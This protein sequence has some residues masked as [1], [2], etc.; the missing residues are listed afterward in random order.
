MHG[1]LADS[2]SFYNQLEY[3]GR[4]FDVFAPDFKGFGKNKGMEYAYSLDD[5]ILDLK[6]YAYKHGLKNPHVIAHSFGARV[7]VKCAANDKDFFDKIV[8]TGA[9]GLKPKLSLIKR[10]KKGA[11]SVLKKFVKK[12]RLKA[13]YSKDYL[14][15]DPVMKESFVKIVNEHLDGL[16]GDIVNETLIIYGSGDKDTP[17]YMAKRFHSGINGSKLIFIEGAG[18]FAFI[19]KPHK[20]NTEVKEFLL[21]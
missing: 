21:S 10:V 15:L 4:N 8:L 19:D 20:F 14:A 7:A 17:P 18:H 1:Y 9:A 3:F 5:Y 6:E 2:N 13:F 16:L 11:F 12:E